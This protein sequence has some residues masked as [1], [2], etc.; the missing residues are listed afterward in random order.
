MNRNTAKYITAFVTLGALLIGTRKEPSRCIAW[1]LG[2][3]ILEN[4]RTVRGAI[5]IDGQQIWGGSY[6]DSRY[7]Q[8]I[9]VTNETGRSVLATVAN[10]GVSICKGKP[11]S[12]GDGV[13]EGRRVT[14]LPNGTDIQYFGGGVER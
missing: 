10:E 6:G 9:F 12:S 14:L 11:G 1:E 7:N 5:T 8:E 4:G 13:G 3:H 2:D